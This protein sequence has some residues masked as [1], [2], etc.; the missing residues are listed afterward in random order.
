MISV[1]IPTLNEAGNL[2]RLLPMLLADDQ[3]IEIIIADG[4]SSDATVLIAK[5]QGAAVVTTR[6]GRGAQLAAGAERASGD[7]LL[8]LHADSRWPRGGFAAIRNALAADPDAPGGNFRLLFE[9]DD[10]FSRWLNGFYAF[11]RWLGFYYGDSGMFAR[12]EIYR[13][14][15]GIK[16][17]AL[18][19]DYDFVRR[20]RRTG[21]AICIKSPALVTS[22]RRFRNRHPV[23]IVGGWVVIHALYFVGVSPSYLA[24]LY[25]SEVH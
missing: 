6:P 16:P 2:C 21:K 13:R 5:E 3:A 17:I 25:R 10:A 9:A 20:L 8:F 19:E 1:V 23:A 11:I 4:G 24:R 18:M 15:G 7:I 22:S 14:L 12:A